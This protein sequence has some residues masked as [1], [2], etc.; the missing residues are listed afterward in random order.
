MHQGFTT[1]QVLAFLALILIFLICLAKVSNKQKTQNY[2]IL[3]VDSPIS[4]VAVYELYMRKINHDV[5]FLFQRPKKQILDVNHKWFDKIPVGR[6]P[7]NDVMKNLSMNAGLSKIYTNHSIRTTVVTNLDRA[8]YE[9]G[10][11]MAP[12]GHKSETSIK[13]YSRMCPSNKRRDI[14]DTLTTTLEGQPQKKK[15]QAM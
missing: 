2:I 6:D 13:N 14:S 11:I 5:N 12:T 1:P 7:L 15:N 4:P 8:G 9:A 10:H 3:I